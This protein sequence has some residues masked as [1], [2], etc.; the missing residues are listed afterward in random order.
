MQ[1]ER[2][3]GIS[4]LSLL[5]KRV[6]RL[7]EDMFL[8]KGGIVAVASHDVL[9]RNKGCVGALL[10]NMTGRIVDDNGQD[11][12]LGEVGEL[13]LYGPNMAK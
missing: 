11:V 7:Q 2:I 4:A 8:M 5:S 13:W 6:I 10:P 9:S 1:L 12:P 3:V